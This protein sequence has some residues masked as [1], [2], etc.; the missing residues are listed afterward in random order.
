MCARGGLVMVIFMIETRPV[1]ADASAKGLLATMYLKCIKRCR[2]SVGKGKNV[3]LIAAIVGGILG[4]SATAKAQAT[5][6]IYVDLSVVNDGGRPGGPGITGQLTLPPSRAPL[7]TLHIAPKKQI[8][9]RAPAAAR[10]TTSAKSVQKSDPKPA[11]KKAAS[12]PVSKL[13][14]VK[15]AKV[16]MSKAPATKAMPPPTPVTKLTTPAPPPAPKIASAPPAA[17]KVAKTPPTTTAA[18]KS[19]APEVASAPAKIKMKPGRALRIAFGDTEARLSDGHKANLVTLANAL[20]EK[21]DFRLQLLAYA[22]GQDLST[23]KARRMSLSRAL[24]VR[25]FLIHKGV[26]ST[27]IDLRALGNKTNEKPVNRVDL[28][29][30]KR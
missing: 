12:K 16:P 27:Q 4:T 25:S 13:T 9:L 30:A 14:P 1:S 24:A 2:N 28:N 3:L 17:P 19:A 20:R 18:P 7:S 8:K 11:P 5:P 26:R 23:S 15:V 22:G 21:K 10:K 29:L 6:N